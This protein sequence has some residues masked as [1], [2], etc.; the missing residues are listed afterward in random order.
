MNG[1]GGPAV[2][3]LIDDGLRERFEGRL[4][5][6]EAQGKGAGAPYEFAQFWVCRRQR[7]DCGLNIVA[8]LVGPAGVR[9]GHGE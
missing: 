6:G 3:L 4:L 2:K 9:A 8:R 1:S 5:R 7:S